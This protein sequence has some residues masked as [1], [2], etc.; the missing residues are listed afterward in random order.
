MNIG[1]LEKVE[2]REIW[3]HEQYDFSKWLAENISI[4]QDVL[5][6]SLTVEETE[7]RVGSFSIDILAK[8][9]DDAYAIIEN[10]LE[11]TDHDHLGK[12]ITYTSNLDAKTA[13]WITKEVRDEHKKAIEWIN[14]NTNSDISLYLIR[15]EAYRIGNSD[16]A[17]LFT[18][19]SS[20]NTLAKEIAKEKQEIDD[21]AKQRYTFW[22]SL[23]VL[24]DKQQDKLH[25]NTKLTHDK[26]FGASSG[27]PGIFYNYVIWKE[28][29]AIELSIQ[30]GKKEKNN[31]IFDM[32]FQK[33]GE[34]EKDFGHSLIWEK[35]PNQIRSYIRF[36]QEECGWGVE[37]NRIEKQEFLIKEMRKLHNALQKQIQTI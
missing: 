19:I 27:T 10:Q 4:L 3:K 34:I 1:T 23:E 25:Q 36:R 12:L 28:E 11:K 8:T 9:D 15:V 6:F 29:S 16:P 17:P 35:A 26:T 22:Q 13:I 24:L 32:L 31:E 33:K 21:R 5:G 37:K 20:P 2:L 7:K 14:K 18:V 30:T